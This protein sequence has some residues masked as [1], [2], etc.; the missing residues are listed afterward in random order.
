MKIYN[1]RVLVLV[2]MLIVSFSS[3]AF[4]YTATQSVFQDWTFDSGIL[5][6]WSGDGHTY[7]YASY[8]DF[9]TGSFPDGGL[10]G[11]WLGSSFG[12]PSSMSWSHSL[13]N[14]SGPGTAVTSAKLFI[15]AA[16]VDGNNNLVSI[17]GTWNW[18]PLNNN[19]IDNS[20]YNLAAINDPS[21]WDDG[22][23]DVSVFAGERDLRIDRAVLM[24]D[25]ETNPGA[26][27]SEVP[28]P[29]TVILF[30]AGLV[31]FSSL[32]RRRR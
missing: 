25:F 23:L 28:E 1:S 31:S 22:S 20:T 14:L 9:Y 5:N 11:A 32:M 2:A 4:G 15:D 27:T 7:D 8:I 10:G 16:W 24:L 13:P 6:G 26:G 3:N 17:A 21:Y 30:G 18:D 29:G 12:L 19:F